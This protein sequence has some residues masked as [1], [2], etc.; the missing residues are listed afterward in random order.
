M[1]NKNKELLDKMQELRNKRENEIADEELD[2][3]V[4]D[5]KYLGKIKWIDEIDGNR[6]EKEK[7]I[8][9]VI[10][11]RNGSMTYKY[12]D[13]NMEM[14]AAQRAT[15]EMAMPSEKYLDREDKSYIEDIDEL[16]KDGKSLEELEQEEKTVGEIKKEEEEEISKEFSTN[17]SGATSLNQMVDRVTLRNIL[18]LDGDYEYIKPIDAS[19]L[20]Q[21]GG[22]I[23]SKQGIVAIKNN[24]ECKILGEDVIRQDRQEGNNSFDRDLN[25]GNDG[26]IEYK[27]NTSSFQIVNRP[28]YYISVSYDS[29]EKEVG[30]TNKEIKISKR[31]GREG[32]NEVE[33]ELQK[34]GSAEYEE[35]DA[36]KL[37][38]ENEEGIGKS[39]ETNKKQEMH[40]KAGCEN[41][42]VEN[43]DEYSENNIHEHFEVTKD[44]IVPGKDITFE[45]WAE[46]LDENSNVIIERFKKDI[47]KNTDRTPEEIAK[48]IEADYERLPGNKNR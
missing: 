25:I 44:S 3:K 38:Q 40:E 15:D 21:F 9:M 33:F 18:N 11:E 30:T 23:S 22:N 1:D 24:G 32:D 4:V 14:L 37:R 7:D 19:I 26:D 20:N 31:S 2:I 43:I 47:E 8:Y 39:D 10:E 13:E 28:Q 48:E 17:T 42:R 46:D 27:S 35:S 5:V 45:K 36:R 29:G 41:D 6:V 34:K 16:D 12:Y